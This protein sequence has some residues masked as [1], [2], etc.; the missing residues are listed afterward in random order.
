MKKFCEFVKNHY[1]A[2][3]KMN[4]FKVFRSLKNPVHSLETWLEQ[5]N[6]Q[7]VHFRH[8]CVQV[9]SETDEFFH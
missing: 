7:T 4:N 9:S 6:F 2:A 8:T 3:T 1:V 5:W